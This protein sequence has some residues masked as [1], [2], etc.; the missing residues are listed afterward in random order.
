MLNVF[1][2][3][4]VLVRLFFVLLFIENSTGRCMG[5]G[6]IQGSILSTVFCHC[7][8]SIFILLPPPIHAS[9]NTTNAIKYL[10]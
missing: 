3:Y 7:I 1:L 4:T 10:A 8:Q 9:H 5:R 6:V 2:P